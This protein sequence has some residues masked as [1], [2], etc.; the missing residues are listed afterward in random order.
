VYC[1]LHGP[2]HDQ[3]GLAALDGAQLI[4]LNS[5]DVVAKYCSERHVRAGLTEAR[6]LT[7]ACEEDCMAR[8]GV[9]NSGKSLS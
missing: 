2:Q 9:S 5:I 1:C 7:F 8:T 4:A 3:L 6:P